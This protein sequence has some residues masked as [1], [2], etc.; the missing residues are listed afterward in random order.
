MNPAVAQRSTQYNTY[1]AKQQ[2][3]VKETICDE[4]TAC[5]ISKH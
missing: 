5:S 4:R 1:K 3:I 2:E